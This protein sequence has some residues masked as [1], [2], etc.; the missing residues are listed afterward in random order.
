LDDW[1]GILRK[2]VLGKISK[3][4]YF[5]KRNPI[6][7]IWFCRWGDAGER[8]KKLENAEGVGIQK[9]NGPGV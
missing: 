8:K 1:I 2:N 7:Q 9:I 4:Y 6:I 3:R 5:E